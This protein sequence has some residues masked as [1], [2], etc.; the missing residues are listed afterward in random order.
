MI[1]A[2][3]RGIESTADVALA[4]DRSGFEVSEIVS[5]GARGVDRAGERIGECCGIPVRVFPAEWKR[6]GKAAGVIRNREMARYA[7]ALVAVW[8]GKSRG[9]KHMI[10]CMKAEGKPYHVIIPEPVPDISEASD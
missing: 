10:D 7:D 2:G 3:S 8:D 6:H 9:T 4:V 1:I 5:G